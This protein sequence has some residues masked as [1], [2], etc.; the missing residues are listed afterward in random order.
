M[1]LKNN[2]LLRT[3]FALAVFTACAL[4]NETARAQDPVQA[5]YRLSIATTEG[6]VDDPDDD[7]A[8]LEAIWR[9]PSDV[10]ISRRN[11]VVKLEN[12][13]PDEF[14]LLSFIIDINNADFVFDAMAILD[15]PTGV[16]PL[17]TAPSDMVHA[18]STSSTLEFDFSDRPLAP[19]ESITFIVEIESAPGTAVVEADFREI[20]WDKNGNVRSDNALLSASFDKGPLPEFVMSETLDLPTIPFYEYP[21]ANQQLDTREEDGASG[22]SQIISAMGMKSGD[23]GHFEIEQSQVVVPEPTSALTMLA[24]LLLLGAR[25]LLRR[26][27]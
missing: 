9:T 8:V 26:Q 27:R 24:G 10:L 19:G 18:S 14:N 12:I 22:R 5:S 16:G 25:G 2:N 13:S 15:A 6:L 20:L 11:P 17:V 4:A 1:S 3:L 7:L 21:F 23:L